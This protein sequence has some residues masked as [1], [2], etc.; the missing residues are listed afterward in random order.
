MFRQ[1]L[2]VADN[3]RAS[4][5]IANSIVLHWRE[6]LR[7][8]QNARDLFIKF[9]PRIRSGIPANPL[10][11]ELRERLA[12]AL[13]FRP[14]S[15]TVAKI[16]AAVLASV[17]A[18]RVYWPTRMNL[19]QLSLCHFDVALNLRG[20][21]VANRHGLRDLALALS[22][23]PVFQDVADSAPSVWQRVTVAGQHV[24]ERVTSFWA[25]HNKLALVEIVIDT[26]YSGS[27]HCR[28]EMFAVDGNTDAF[29]SAITRRQRNRD[30]R[31]ALR[32]LVVRQS[33]DARAIQHD[34]VFGP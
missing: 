19:R 21:S 15:F 3:L 23:R 26:P 18:Q 1:V 6:N 5:T 24:L 9:L 12:Y 7:D 14:A 32:S 20:S 33:F 2:Q 8:T 17:H 13:A 34:P 11:R 28:F 31:S 4:L 29:V 30:E 25:T 22:L 10:P 16:Y 27:R